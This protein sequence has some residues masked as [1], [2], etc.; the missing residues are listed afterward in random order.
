MNKIKFSDLP[1]YMEIIRKNG[2][3]FI[4]KVD[5]ERESNFFTLVITFA[6]QEFD[7]LRLDHSDLEEGINLVLE[8]Y[9]KLK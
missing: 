5:G 7:S 9:F 6:N 3:V 8:E 1:K 4:L 2:D